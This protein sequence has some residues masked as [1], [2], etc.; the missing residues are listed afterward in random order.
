MKLKSVLRAVPIASTQSILNSV[1]ENPFS[2]SKSAIS[3]VSVLANGLPPANSRRF[4]CEAELRRRFDAME[5]S[6]AHGPG[7]A[8]G[9]QRPAYAPHGFAPFGG[10]CDSHRSAT[11]TA[12]PPGPADASASVGIREAGSEGSAVAVP[13]CLPHAR[14]HGN[15]RPRVNVCLRNLTNCVTQPGPRRDPGASGSFNSRRGKA[16]PIDSSS[17]SHAALGPGDPALSGCC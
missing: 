16:G 1:C 9:D 7:Q 13:P 3:W 2:T 15:T 14:G 17:R 5:A 8:A 4:G 12:Q 6:S 10:P 11:P